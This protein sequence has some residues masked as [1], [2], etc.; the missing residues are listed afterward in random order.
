MSAGL[1]IVMRSSDRD[2]KDNVVELLN[3]MRL[4]SRGPKDVASTKFEYET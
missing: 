1:F 4:I 3:K 2:R